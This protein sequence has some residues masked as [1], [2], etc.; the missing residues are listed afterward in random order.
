MN[1]DLEMMKHPDRW[2]LGVALPLKRRLPDH[3]Y[4]NGYLLRPA[5]EVFTGNLYAAAV[6]P[7]SE[8]VM[9]ASL[10]DVVKA[11]WLVD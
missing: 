7:G 3:S 6:L 10:E 11:G 2:P 5:P 9:Y 4:Q 8:P 1:D